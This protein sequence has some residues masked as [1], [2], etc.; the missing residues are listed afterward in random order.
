VSVPLKEQATNAESRTEQRSHFAKEKPSM[1]IQQQGQPVAR[2]KTPRNPY[3]QLGALVAVALVAFVVTWLL[4]RGG[5]DS[6]AVPVPAA[7][8]PTIVTEAQLRGLAKKS[9]F[10]VYWAGAKKGA[11]EFTR[12]SDGRIYIR[13]LNSTSQVGSRAARFLTVGT[14]PRKAAFL[15]I[16]R[17]AR[18]PG[19]LSLK[20]GSNGLLVFNTNAPT[21][22]YFSYPA[23][24]YQVEV[25]D[26]SPQQARTLV[27]A[28][29]ITPIH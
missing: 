15:S 20:L 10:P 22:V 2:V 16:R 7:G 26:P 29:K 28:G 23:A 1:E 25:Y 3:V 27:L 9:A 6:T 19:G 12:T 8:K 13:Y 14:Y 24:K 21:S 4:I 5:N 11:Y 17:A 18:R